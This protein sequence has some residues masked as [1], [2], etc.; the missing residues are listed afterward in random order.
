LTVATE[1][2]YS[3]VCPTVISE[4]NL[5]KSVIYFRQI[6]HIF[7]LLKYI[8]IQ[9]NYPDSDKRAALTNMSSN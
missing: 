9:L 7:T 4:E 6:I 2:R 5:L 3:S 1:P 8:Q